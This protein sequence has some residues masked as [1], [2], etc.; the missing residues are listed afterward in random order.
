MFTN[1]TRPISLRSFTARLSQMRRPSQL[2]L[3]GNKTLSNH[4]TMS[5][6]PAQQ[7]QHDAYTLRKAQQ[8]K[9]QQAESCSQTHRRLST[10]RVHRQSETSRKSQAQG[11]NQRHDPN[12]MKTLPRK[13]VARRPLQDLHPSSYSQRSNFHHEPVSHDQNAPS[14]QQDCP[15]RMSDIYCMI[16]D[17]LE[18]NMNSYTNL[19]TPTRRGSSGTM[20]VDFDDEGEMEV[21]YRN[22]VNKKLPAVPLAPVQLPA[23]PTPLRRARPLTPPRYNSSTSQ[24]S[25]H[26]SVISS[27]LEREE[28]SDCYFDARPCVPSKDARRTRAQNVRRSYPPQ[29]HQTKLYSS[30]PSI[31]LFP[32]FSP[33]PTPQSSNVH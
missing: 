5:I 15:N 2:S 12:L 23:V 21:S 33:P 10:D 27:G 32:L 30:P 26:D 1:T 6:Y 9:S 4:T 28:N 24:S 22:G 8:S 31:S 3:S 25:R 20:F 14:P 18:W 29:V 16:D 17:H 11:Y 19:S 13:P 7:G